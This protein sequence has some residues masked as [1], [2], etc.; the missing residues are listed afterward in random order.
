MLYAPVRRDT[1]PKLNTSLAR[2]R[3]L[4]GRDKLHWTLYITLAAEL[5]VSRAPFSALLQSRAAV[6]FE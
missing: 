5:A 4:V 1:D 2:S 6:V 3:R